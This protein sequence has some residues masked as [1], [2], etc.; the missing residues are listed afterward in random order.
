MDN[1]RWILLAV[2][3]VIIVIIYLISRK[4]KREFYQYDDDVSEDLPEVKTSNWDDL[5]EGVGE[6]R[7]VA[8]AEDV[9]LQEDQ[10]KDA[11]YADDQYGAESA[12]AINEYDRP[13]VE[14]TAVHDPQS[15]LNP[16]TEPGPLDDVQAE[17]EPQPVV[18][19][20]AEAEVTE[21]VLVLN[22][23][24]RDGSALSGKSINSVAHANNMEFGEM[25]IY[26]R[27]DENNQPL[28]SMINMVKPGSFDPSTIH[29]LTTPGVSL[30]LQLPS[31]ICCKRPPACLK[32]WKRVYV[33][34]AGSL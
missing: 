24:A 10:H 25:D 11:A 21:A 19:Q 4:N 16:E 30:F 9:D 2:G 18:E 26:H 3:I 14:R 12:D 17:S 27:M 31:M 6:V 7:I 8:R 1:F 23:L 15:R 22:I 20:K 33:T 5:D 28:F 32:Y 29:E 13:V 34:K